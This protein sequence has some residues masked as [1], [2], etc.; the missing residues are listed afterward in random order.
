MSILDGRAKLPRVTGNDAGTTNGRRPRT[1]EPAAGQNDLANGGE[2]EG[3]HSRWGR[4]RRATVTNQAESRL[5]RRKGAAGAQAN[6]RAESTGAVPLI[7]KGNSAVRM[8]K[9]NRINGGF[10]NA[11]C[12]VQ[13]EVGGEDCRR[14][15]PWARAFCITSLRFVGE[16]SPDDSANSTGSK[17]VERG[18]N[19]CGTLQNTRSVASALTSGGSSVTTEIEMALTFY[20]SRPDCKRNRTKNPKKSAILPNRLRR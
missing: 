20:P 11:D 8:L 12:S 5:A 6:G 14:G 19:A 2:V 1:N 18:G 9:P 16:P 3:T 4:V 7:L 17:P 10:R 15:D 13:R